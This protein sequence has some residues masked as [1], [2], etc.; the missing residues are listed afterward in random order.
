MKQSI[1]SKQPSKLLKASEMPEIWVWIEKV[2]KKTNTK[3][4]NQ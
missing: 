1:D 2:I 3:R 4:I